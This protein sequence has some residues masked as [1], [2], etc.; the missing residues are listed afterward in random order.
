MTQARKPKKTA[1]KSP[2]KAQPIVAFK[3]LDKDFACKGFQFA[4]GK[5]YKHDGKVEICQSGFHSC[6]NPLDV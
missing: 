6:E 3:G 5:T 1:A 4:V 2:A